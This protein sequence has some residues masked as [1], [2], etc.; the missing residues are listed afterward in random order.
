VNIC[1]FLSIRRRRTNVIKR[2]KRLHQKLPYDLYE[3]NPTG[4]KLISKSNT[5]TE[6]TRIDS[7]ITRF[8]N[9]IIPI[10]TRRESKEKKA[11]KRT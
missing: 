11:V 7:E 4:M 3:Y 8:L 2:L 9:L 6:K 1:S 10:Q 5:D